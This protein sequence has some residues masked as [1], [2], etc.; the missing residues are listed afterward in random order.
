MTIKNIYTRYLCTGLFDCIKIDT[1]SDGGGGQGFEYANAGP[2]A[3]LCGSIVCRGQTAEAAPP[4]LHGGTPKPHWPSETPAHPATDR[5]AGA[6]DGGGGCIYFLLSFSDVRKT[7]RKSGCSIIVLFCYT[8]S[9][10]ML[11]PDSSGTDPGQCAVVGWPYIAQ[12]RP[13]GWLQVKQ[14]AESGSETLGDDSYQI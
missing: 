11:N 13:P 7:Q 12:V 9:C 8:V 1:A 6:S 3:R 14:K 5:G 10:I 2:C 4:P